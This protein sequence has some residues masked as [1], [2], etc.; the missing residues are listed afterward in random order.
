MSADIKFDASEIDAL[1]KAFAKLPGEIKAKAF[2]R[3]M[4]RMATM[5][6]TRVVRI[7]ARRTDLSQSLI[8]ELTTAALNTGTAS[9]EVVMKSG[10]LPLYDLPH[11][12]TP[13]GAEVPGRGLLKSAFKAKM[14]SGHEGIF[15]NSGGYN[16]KSKRNNAVKELFGPNPAHD[17]TNNPEEFI[18]ILAELIEEHLAPRF[19]HEIGRLLPK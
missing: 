2:A 11:T 14:K 9:A 13:E 7:S 18:K 16:K 1:G 15:I 5:S 8:R 4:K 19:L 6:R 12:I 17:V 3:A 10:W